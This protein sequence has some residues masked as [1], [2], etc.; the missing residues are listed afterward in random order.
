VGS[1]RIGK[2]LNSKLSGSGYKCHSLRIEPQTGIELSDIEFTKPSILII[3]ISAVG[4][5]WTWD[6]VLNGL[7]AQ[8]RN[9]E[10][11]LN[12]IILV[13]STRVYEGHTEG[14][15]TSQESV[16]AESAKAAQI[17]VAED[18]LLECSVDSWIIRCSGLYGKDYPR[19]TPIMIA[20]EGKPRSGVQTEQVVEEIYQFIRAIPEFGS[21]NGIQLLTDGHCYFEGKKYRQTS[22]EVKRLS[23][24]HKV[25]IA[26]S[27]IL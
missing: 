1:G 26:S 24:A 2:P 17:I 9:K 23:K 10:I 13:S 18:A 16:A 8:I 22:D 15:V 14:M 7:L 20:A 12:Q 25:L 3:C 21:K 27:H 4:K 5:P 6:K 19:Y 11:Y